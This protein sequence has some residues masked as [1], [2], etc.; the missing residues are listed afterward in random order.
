MKIAELLCNTFVQQEK[1]VVYA[2]IA[3]P[4][5]TQLTPVSVEAMR[6]SIVRLILDLAK[7]AVT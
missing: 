2:D 6:A 7:K 5:R 4:L 3:D 1:A